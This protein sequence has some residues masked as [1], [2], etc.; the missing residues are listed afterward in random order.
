LATTA[1]CNY[2]AHELGGNGLVA[3]FVAG[4]ACAVWM[5]VGIVA[6]SHLES[7]EAEPFVSTVLSVI[8]TTV[9]LSVLAHG[10]TASP[11]SLRYGS[12]ANRNRPTVESA[13]VTESVRRHGSSPRAVIQ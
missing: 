5:V 7:L 6:T 13:E 8:A 1:R 11:W 3:A 10:L 4:T 12:W 2:G 9:V